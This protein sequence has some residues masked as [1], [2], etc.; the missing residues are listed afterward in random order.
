MSAVSLVMHPSQKMTD[1]NTSTPMTH[2]DFRT[3][4]DNVPSLFIPRVYANIQEHRIRKVFEEL[5]LGTLERIDVV[6][7]CE[8]G[9]KFNRVYVHFSRWNDTENANIARER[10]LNGKEIKVIYDEP[11]FW[12]ISAYKSMERRTPKATQPPTLTFD[13]NGTATYHSRK[14]A[15]YTKKQISIKE[16]KDDEEGEEEECDTTFETRRSTEDD[17]VQEPLNYGD[18]TPTTMLRQKKKI[19]SH[20]PHGNR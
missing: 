10:L 9:E 18:I 16:V 15:Q 12:R 4:P 8:K 6:S 17:V 11:W 20:V 19:S 13:E 1:T 2:I 3:L 7:K 14:P 5:D